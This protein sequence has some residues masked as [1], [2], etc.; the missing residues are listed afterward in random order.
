M[1][2]RKSIQRG[3]INEYTYENGIQLEIKSLQLWILFFFHST[4]IYH[5]DTCRL[6]FYYEC[7]R[8]GARINVISSK[9]MI[10]LENN[11]NT[12]NNE[13]IASFATNLFSTLK[14]IPSH[15]EDV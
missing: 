10:C 9:K 3:L 14:K 2:M 13:D 4:L 1:R 5:H 8:N 7:D 15:I 11:N 12:N 6:Q